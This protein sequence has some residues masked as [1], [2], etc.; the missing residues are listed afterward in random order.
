MI[1]LDNSATTL[2]KPKEVINAVEFALNHLTA[3]PGRSGHKQS[4]KV[5]EFVFETREKLKK[6]LNAEEYDVIFT[7]NCT[8]ALNLAIQGYLKPN[9]HVITTCYEHNS[10]LRTLNSLKDKNIEITILNCDLKDFH[11][12]FPKYIKDN[13]SLIITTQ[14]SNVTGDISDIE[15][16]GQVCKNRNIKYLVDG[17]Q[18][19]G[20]MPIDLT[21]SN[22]DMFAFAGHK[23]FYSITGIGGLLVKKDTQLSPIIFGGTGTDSINLNQPK[24]IPEGFESGTIPSIAI[25]SLNGGI[26]F[27]TKN[28]SNIIKKE[29]NL[30]K[31]LYKKLKNLNFL[32]IYSKNEAQNV[33]SFNVKNK[34]SAF[35]ANLLDEKFNICVR[36][37]LHCA[38]LIHKKLDTQTTGAIR[39]SLNYFNSEEDLDVLIKALN[40]INNL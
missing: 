12:E 6:I 22:V 35:V 27:L 19:A 31:N 4:S 17:A 3:N 2:K 39:V 26:E 36:S 10:V 32:E 16:I 28:F 18:S 11:T 37:G 24:E 33:F 21:K 20:H 15:K 14:V 1:Y 38:P 30:S 7:K 13:T 29:E 8:E 23:G 9:Q 25:A 5:S 34:D 40:Y